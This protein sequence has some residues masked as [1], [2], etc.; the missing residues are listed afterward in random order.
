MRLIAAAALAL[1]SC[2]YATKPNSTSATHALPNNFFPPQVFKNLNLLRNINLEKGYPR[3]TIN[4]LVENAGDTPQSKYYVPFSSE[5]ISKVGGF[6]A[7]EKNAESNGKFKVERTHI[8][9]QNSNQYFII[10]LRTPLPPSSRLSLSLS[11]YLLSAIEPLP[12]AIEQDAKQY[13]VYDFSAYAPSA[14]VTNMQRTKLKFPSI[15][16]PDYT[17]T[18]GL[19]PSSES[20]PEKQ[21]STFTYGPYKTVD[22]T[23]GTVEPVTVRYEFSRPVIMSTLLE[24]DI[25]VSHWGGNLATED[26]YWLQ[27]NGAHLAKQFSR[28]TWSMK[29]LENSPSVAISALRVILT[30]GAVDPYFI[31]DIGNVSTSRF[32][33]GRGK[34]G[35][36]LDIRPRFPVFGGWK[37]SFRI[38]WNEALSSFLRKS[39]SDDTYILKVPFLDC[40]RMPEGIQYEKL[41][42]RVILPEGASEVKYELFG[43]VGV[44]ND[45][46]SEILLHKTFM[47]TLGRTVLKLTATNIA[48]EA[49]DV[50]LIVTYNY[51]FAASLRKPITI[52]VGVLSVF[53]AAWAISNVD[54][55]IKKR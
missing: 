51:P 47:D 17:V 10:H 16:V 53:V 14:Y 11:Y 31:D 15:N 48:D 50:Q 26:R 25:E 23:P 54:V 32:S 36:L 37:Y 20:D 52:F 7:W 45:I 2:V 35:G 39:K 22:I 9:S 49:R 1:T 42:L 18:N 30:P 38:G 34:G 3:E 28:V 55:S 4:I 44:P 27:N 40:P 46:H 8:R 41:D 19:K 24:R 12:A 43:G 13:L 5:V 6:E 33:P 29:T 21:G